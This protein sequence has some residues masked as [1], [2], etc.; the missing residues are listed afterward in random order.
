MNKVLLLKI[1]KNRFK[2]RIDRAG[3]VGI[4]SNKASL[5]TRA[6]FL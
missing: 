2:N 1:N 4:K 3:A 6:L 5:H